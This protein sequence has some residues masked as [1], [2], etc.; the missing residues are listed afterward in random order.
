MQAPSSEKY[1]V[2]CEKEFS[3]EHEGKIAL[4][5]RAL[6]G[7]KLAGRDF[8]THLRSCINFLGFKSCQANPDI[9]MIE[10]TN[11][12]GTDYWE[13]VILYMDAFLVVSDHSEN[14]LREEI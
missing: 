4:I 11:T 3:L 9:W 7:G 10:A 6:Y 13:Y 5:R 12:D 2:I 1:Y 14:M 8:W